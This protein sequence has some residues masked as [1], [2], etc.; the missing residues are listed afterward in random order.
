MAGTGPPWSFGSVPIGHL[1]S[2][3][4]GCGQMQ[5]SNQEAHQRPQHPRQHSVG[6][7]ESLPLVEDI[8]AVNSFFEFLEDEGFLFPH[9]FHNHQRNQIDS[10]DRHGT[11][12]DKLDHII[13]DSN[14]LLESHLD[15]ITEEHGRKDGEVLLKEHLQPVAVVA[16]KM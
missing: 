1:V 14:K 16:S 8:V 13:I 4:D 6:T 10:H 2:D 7:I 3:R 12:H 11:A 5:L 15:A 9:S